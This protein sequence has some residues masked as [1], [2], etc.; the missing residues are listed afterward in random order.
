VYELDETGYNCM[1]QF[2]VK[3]GKEEDAKLGASWCPEEAISIIE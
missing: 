3:P 1:G 2:E